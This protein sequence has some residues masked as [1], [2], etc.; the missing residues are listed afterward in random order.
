MIRTMLA[1]T[2]VAA[3]MTGA[4]LAQNSFGVP[5]NHEGGDSNTVNLLIS[6]TVPQECRVS[7]FDNGSFTYNGPLAANDTL[8]GV[9]IET[10]CNY[11]PAAP[12]LEVS[13]ANA[14]ALVNSANSSQTAD[15]KLGNFSGGC[16]LEALNGLRL[17]SPRTATLQ[18]VDNFAVCGRTF[19]IV[20]IDDAVTAGTWE[21]TITFTVTEG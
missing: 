1:A 4:S 6:A 16:G 17:D 12:V 8:G 9:S 13:S 14:G 7:Y 3:L 11:G 18:N 20:M 15:Y 21:D 19:R 5:D 2:A 10:R